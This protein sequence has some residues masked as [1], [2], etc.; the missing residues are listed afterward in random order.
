MEK[1]RLETEAYQ[2]QLNRE[3]ELADQILKLVQ[4]NAEDAGQAF[5]ILQ[6]LS[7]LV[8][9]TY[10]VD[11]KDKENSKVASTRRQRLLEY[12]A[13][14]VDLMTEPEKAEQTDKTPPS[15]MG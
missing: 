9:D 2:A 1:S 11:W 10:K 7:I 3:E 12:I 5:V 8:W 14:L 4:E 15:A 6:K 13:G